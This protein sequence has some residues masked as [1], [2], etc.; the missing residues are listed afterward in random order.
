MLEAK[1]FGQDQW[2]GYKT[3]HGCQEVLGAT[4]KDWVKKDTE[5][6]LSY[7]RVVERTHRF[8]LGGY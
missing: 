7:Y 3:S 1:P 6:A 2:D 4:E 8:V 5:L